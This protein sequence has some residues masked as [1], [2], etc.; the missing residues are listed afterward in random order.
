MSI[1]L[2]VMNRQD[3]DQVAALWARCEGISDP[4]TRGQVEAL[5]QAH[6]MLSW[7]ACENQEIVATVLAGQDGRRGYLYHLAVD[8]PYRR[9][10]I[11]RQLVVR[12]LEQ[13]D[14]QGIP[15][16]SVFVYRDNEAADQLWTA[17]GWRQRSELKVFAMDLP[18]VQGNREDE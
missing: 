6:P 9:Q 15:R 8:E 17:L 16:C 4:D 13:L 3:Y 5:L 2:R 1:E 7:L 11:A 18:A 12:C 10:G 14:A